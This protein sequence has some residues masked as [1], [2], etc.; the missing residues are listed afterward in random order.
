MKI[1]LTGINGQVGYELH[2]SL[3]GLGQV[4]AFDRKGLDLADFDQLRNVIRE[5]KPALIINPA[6][7]TAVDRAECDAE[8][9]MRING[10]APGIMA[11][12]AAKIGAAMIH[13]STDYVFDGSKAGSYTEQDAPCPINVYGKTKLEGESAI[14]AANIPHLILR[15]SWVY[16]M[17]GN[18]FLKT[19]LRL[20]AQRNELKIVCD[21]FGAPTWS[22]TIAEIT[23][24]IVAKISNRDPKTFNLKGYSGI[25]NLT[26]QGSTTWH[27]FAQAVLE[28]AGLSTISVLPISSAEYPIPAPRPK[29]SCLS[30]ARLIDTFCTL[31]EWRE[32]LALCQ[33]Q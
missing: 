13:Y 30:S 25:Y 16:G 33:R 19:I 15:T 26:A 5:V 23:S 17:R 9:A 12:E 28:N 22:R 24:H 3:Q 18:N 8:L 4:V 1:L 32:A 31:P 2:R 6:A 20:A 7:Y 10:I 21:Q 11:E 29:N 27:G 14:Q